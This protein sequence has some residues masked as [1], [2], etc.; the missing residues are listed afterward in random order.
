MP[1]H[2]MAPHARNFRSCVGNWL[3]THGR[4]TTS[5]GPYPAVAPIGLNFCEFCRN[6]TACLRWDTT[7]IRPYPAA[8]PIWHNFGNSV[9]NRP[10][11]RCAIRPRS[12]LIRALAGG[13][14]IRA[15]RGR[16]G[17]LHG[18][19]CAP[20]SA[21]PATCAP[22]AA[23]D[24]GNNCHIQQQTFTFRQTRA[25]LLKVRYRFRQMS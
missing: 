9:G 18:A 3:Y 10:F 1:H 7:H 13:C 8:S 24:A 23:I 2:I 19:M 11:T 12:G 5:T 4:A 21:T 25:P 16:I 17:P 6:S 15:F 14:L 22:R 20:G